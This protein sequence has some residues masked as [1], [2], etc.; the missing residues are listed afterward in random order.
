VGAKRR[1]RAGAI[2]TPPEQTAKAAEPSEAILRLEGITKTFEGLTAL[3][4]IGFNVTRGH[5]KALIGPNGAGKTTLLNVISGLLKPDVGHIYFDNVDLTRKRPHDITSLGIARTFQLIRLFS[6]NDATVL[7]NVML[8]A[9]R[10]LRP[11][12][13]EALFRGGHLRKRNALL[14]EDAQKTL[15]FVGLGWASSYVPSALSFGDQRRV[16]MARALMAQPQLLLLDE[17]A[18][19]L[20]DAEV[21]TFAGLLREIRGRGITI[22]LIEH[23]MKLVMEI[24]DDI[25]VLDFGKKLAEGTPAEVSGNTEVIEAYLGQ[26]YL[27]SCEA[28]L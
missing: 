8:G 14:E 20:N 3:S 26:E 19:G 9:H 23:N 24:A 4:E 2:V 12:V 1:I 10:R 18:S 21:E 16:E 27:D 6:A 17:P 7:D 25:V 15:D 11:G 28:T 22:L 5:I 13:I